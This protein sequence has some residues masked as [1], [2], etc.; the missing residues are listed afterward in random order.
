[1]GNL[2]R[3]EARGGAWLEVTF[4]GPKKINKVVVYTLDSQKYP[5]SK[6]GFRGASLQVMGTENTWLTV[7]RIEKGIIIP[8]SASADR[9][10]R[11][12]EGRIC[13]KFRPITT[14]KIRFVVY[15]SNDVKRPTGSVATRTEHSIAR[16]V[17]IEATGFEG[18]QPG[19]QKVSS[20]SEE[21]TELD[22]LLNE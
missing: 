12:A 6:H 7:G 20:I 15:Q 2:E 21:E 14:D 22:N 19:Q 13:F 18:M 5:A 10:K 4:P 11:P 9:Q 16:I 1:M 17:E 8:T 3:P